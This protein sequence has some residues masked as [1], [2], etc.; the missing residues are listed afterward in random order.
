MAKVDEASGQIDTSN[1]AYAR[2]GIN[3]GNAPR[4]IGVEPF[5]LNMANG[6]TN[7]VP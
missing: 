7:P 5:S 4:Q 2:E 6:S 3:G 1:L